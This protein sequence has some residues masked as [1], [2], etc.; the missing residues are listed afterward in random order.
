MAAK[1]R[2]RRLVL[3]AALVAVAAAIA[4]VF[5]RQGDEGIPTDPAELAEG[6]S[7]SDEDLSAAIP[8]W[9][10]SGK[11]GVP[12]DVSVDAAYLE[13]AARLLAERPELAPETLERLEP[14]L[15]NQVGD[16]TAAAADFSKLFGGADVEVELETQEPRPLPELI[17]YYDEA[18]R[19]FGVGA[20]Y[21]AAINLTETKFGRVVS[22]SSAGAQGPMQFI[23]ST[24][25]A[26]GLGGDVQDPHDAIVGAANYLSSSGAPGDY[27][28]AL[29]AYNPSR[30]Y[31]DAVK[32]YA[33]LIAA[34]PDAIWL[35]YAWEA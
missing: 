25:K 26:Y 32:R 3:F 8:L 9:R 11:A 19:R 16:M 20:E 2:R 29:L 18:E 35:L 28:R 33:G 27:D 1:Y 12:E 22:D 24:W 5:S 4:L 7:A 34:D 15:A 6:I 10:D 31:V 23:P 17:G 14:A 13:D 30:A 21:L